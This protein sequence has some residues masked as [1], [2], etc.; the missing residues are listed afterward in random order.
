MANSMALSEVQV[1]HVSSIPLAVVR[2]Q[3]HASELAVAVPAGCGVVW[4]FVRAHQLRAG[5][6]VAVYWD[7]A[8]RLEVGVELNDS[9][10][11]G[12]DIVPSA[13]PAGL[14]ASV[15]HLGP[16]DQLGTAHRAIRDWCAAHG[17]QL[18]GPNWEIYG[19]WQNDWN[20]DP[21]Q[22]RTDVFYQLASRGSS[23][24]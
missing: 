10:P 8:I 6:N 12:G 1:T 15:V 14:A 24:G 18:A 23:A 20:A 5:R 7:G 9:L 22:I 4:S 16:Y 17:H 11:D 21:S 19:H 2:R 13:T 3:A